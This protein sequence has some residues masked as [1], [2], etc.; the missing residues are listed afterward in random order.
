[1]VE[2]LTD[3]WPVCPGPIHDVP[4]GA[5]PCAVRAADFVSQKSAILSSKSNSSAL[6]VMFLLSLFSMKYNKTKH[7]STKVQELYYA[8]L[9]RKVLQSQCH[10]QEALFFQLATCALQAEV[11]D[12]ELMDCLK[13]VEEQEKS[14]QDGKRK[15]Y[16]LPE[17]YFPAWVK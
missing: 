10:L 17:D 6:I 1:M 15:H 11:G 5:V 13:T 14:R 4:E 7:R 8:E 2:L 16:F 9:R 12:L 3:T